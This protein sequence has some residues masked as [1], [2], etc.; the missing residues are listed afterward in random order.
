MDWVQTKLL[1]HNALSKQDVGV[2]EVLE[3]VRQT[4]ARDELKE[5]RTKLA[6]QEETITSLKK[7][8]NTE[9]SVPLL[10][11]EGQRSRAD[12]YRA[13]E[14]PRAAEENANVGLK[15]SMKNKGGSGSG[16]VSPAGT[17]RTRSIAGVEGSAFEKPPSRRDSGAKPANT[18]STSSALS[19]LQIPVGVAE[20]Q[21]IHSD[22]K[23]GR[24]ESMGDEYKGEWI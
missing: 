4:R 8:L 12:S 22:T 6:T 11:A 16:L 23:K 5:L 15:S 21:S 24:S 20:H 1:Y 7:K 10:S 2:S 3:H 14:P 9:E 13:V 18:A 19:G 17:P